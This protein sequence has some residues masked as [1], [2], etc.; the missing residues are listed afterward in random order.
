MRMAFVTSWHISTSSVLTV[1]CSHT[2]GGHSQLYGAAAAPVP[3]PLFVIRLRSPCCAVH[4]GNLNTET[5]NQMQ[6]GEIDQ[7][8]A[9]ACQ[10]MMCHDSGSVADVRLVH[11]LQ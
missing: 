4:L 3:T 9:D 5:C 10:C 7:L 1:S 11:G 2:V 8:R 6:L